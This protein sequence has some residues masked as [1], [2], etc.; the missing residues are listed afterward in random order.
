MQQTGTTEKPLLRVDG[1]AMVDRVISALATSNR[2]DRIVAA[3]SP[4]TPETNEFLKSKGI[5]TM[6]TAG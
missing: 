6:Q 5:E 1:V 2:F 3:V 4:N